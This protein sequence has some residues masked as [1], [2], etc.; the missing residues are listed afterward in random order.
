VSNNLEI[1]ILEHLKIHSVCSSKELHHV[2]DDIVSYATT[3]RLLFKLVQ[4]HVLV[5][6]GQGR[7][8]KYYI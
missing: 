3:K 6:L 4:E 7:S 5:T 2:I 1:R 8:T